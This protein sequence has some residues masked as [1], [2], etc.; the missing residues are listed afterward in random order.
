[1]DWFKIKNFVE[2]ENDI[3]KIKYKKYSQ[4]YEDGIIK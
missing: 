4:N 3:D 1:M 2:Y